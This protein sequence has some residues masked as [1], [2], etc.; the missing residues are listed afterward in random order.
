M[1]MKITDQMIKAKHKEFNDRVS[2]ALNRKSGSVTANQFSPAIQ[3][4]RQ[5]AQLRKPALE[6]PYVS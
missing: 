1:L 4:L 3:R 5:L 6:K 2:A